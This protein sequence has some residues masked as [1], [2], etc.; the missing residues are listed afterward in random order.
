MSDNLPISSDSETP[1]SLKSSSTEGEHAA[2]PVMEGEKPETG[3]SSS[4]L[5]STATLC[6]WCR[7]FNFSRE[8]LDHRY[9][10]GGLDLNATFNTWGQL[11][12][13]AETCPLC[14]IILQGFEKRWAV[15]SYFKYD[16]S[17]ELNSDSEIFVSIWPWDEEKWKETRIS[18]FVVSRNEKTTGHPINRLTECDLRAYQGKGDDKT[19]VRREGTSSFPLDGKLLSLTEPLLR[20]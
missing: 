14:K 17:S 18:F 13:T 10:P 15:E 11:L 20:I 1:P 8:T 6:C 9:R 19:E 3:V 5:L 4:A 16:F 7:E 2:M 12:S